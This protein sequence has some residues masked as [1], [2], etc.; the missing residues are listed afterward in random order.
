MTR[1]CASGDRLR[2]ILKSH[3]HHCPIDCTRASQIPSG[4]ALGD[5][6]PSSHH[7]CTGKTHRNR[8]KFSIGEKKSWYTIGNSEI[9]SH[10][11]KMISKEFAGVLSSEPHVHDVDGARPKRKFDTKFAAEQWL[12][13][14]RLEG[15]QSDDITLACIRAIQGHCS[16]PTA[17]REFLRKMFGIPHGWTNVIYHSSSQHYLDTIL[18]NGLIAGRIG[19]N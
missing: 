17:N 10:E 13:Q 5:R 19:R 4:G 18:L 12:E 11:P 3:R 7:Q 6:L 14:R 2:S 9:N 8:V 16:R 15:Y 1:I